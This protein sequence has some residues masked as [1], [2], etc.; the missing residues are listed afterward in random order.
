[1]FI[2]LIGSS[3]WIFVL[4]LGDLKE[5]AY[6]EQ[7]MLANTIADN[8]QSF[9]DKGYAITEQLAFNNS[10]INFN[11]DLQ[12]L[13]LDGTA[14]RHPYFDLLYIQGVDGMQT[15]RFVGELGD[16]SNRWWFIQMMEDNSSFVSKS[17]YS[18]ACNKPV[19]SIF[20]PIYRDDSFVGIMGADMSLDALQV[21]IEEKSTEDSYA[22]VLDGEG[23][24]IAHPDKKQ[25]SEQYNY[26]T[27]EKIIQIKDSAGN[28]VK[29]AKGNETTTT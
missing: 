14:K 12:K 27:L 15:A 20:F 23:V 4:S 3:V 21:M 26:K 11:L 6:S 24:V 13:A 5:K 29:D 2:P 8:V 10:I 19:T 22:Y 25:V 9:V 16:R 28:I 17:Y 18:L 1:M 7:T